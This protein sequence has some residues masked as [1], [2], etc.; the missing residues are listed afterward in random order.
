M[1][2]DSAVTKICTRSDLLRRVDANI[3]CGCKAPLFFTTKDFPMPNLKIPSRHEPVGQRRAYFLVLLLALLW[4]ADPSDAFCVDRECFMIL[5]GRNATADGS[6]LL[7]HNNDLSGMEI[8]LVEKHPRRDRAPGESVVFPTG[9]EIPGSPTTFEWLVLRIAEGFEEGDAV[10]VNEYQVAIAGGVALGRDRLKRAEQADPL[11]ENGLTGGVRYIALQRSRTAREC[12]EM[13]GRWYT[14]YGV[15]YPSGFGVAD[16]DEVWYIESGGGR[17]WAAVRVPD[18]SYWVQANGYRIG[19]IDPSDTS[20]VI[21]SPG[22][23][24]FCETQRLWNPDEGPFSFKTSFGGKYK[25]T[26]GKDRY[27]TLRVWRGMDLLSPSLDLDPGADEFPMTARPDHPVTV[28]T[29]TRILRDHYEGTPFDGYPADGDGS[30]ERLI[31]SPTCVHSDVIQLRGGLP[32]DIGAVMW[33][34]LSRP[35]AGVYVPFYFGIDEVPGPYA[36]ADESCGSAFKTFETL[37]N[38]VLSS[39][40]LGSM[41]VHRGR[42]SLETGAISFQRTIDE[43]AAELY[44]KDPALARAFIST[45]VAGLCAESLDLAARLISELEAVSGVGHE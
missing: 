33:V 37:S 36:C 9:L 2:K 16:P 8:S 22:L 13:V 35:D 31:C 45:Y 4:T 12:V 23:L 25:S 43:T 11:V 44:E 3:E 6:V 1:G 14:R 39:Y 18:D 7:A 10:A 42:E 32:A 5:V 17:T 27:N 29:L 28:E 26:P 34:G 40:S 30:G 19:V 20:N 38:L 41:K 15:S 24:E 21:T